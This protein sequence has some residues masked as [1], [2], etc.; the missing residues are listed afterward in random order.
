MLVAAH[1]L[2]HL[3]GY[4]YKQPNI[5]IPGAV[6]MSVENVADEVGAEFIMSK[7]IENNT[8]FDIKYKE[9]DQCN[10]KFRKKKDIKTC[11][12]TIQAGLQLASLLSQLNGEIPPTLETMDMSEVDETN[13]TYGNTACRLTNYY[14][15]ALKLPSYPTCWYKP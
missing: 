10:S 8:Y 5:L 1:E 15:G 4:L 2:S 11:S 9:Y 12:I 7:M 14:W 13:M 3:T 6:R